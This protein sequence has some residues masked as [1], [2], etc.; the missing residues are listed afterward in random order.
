M[1]CPTASTSEGSAIT[2][3]SRCVSTRRMSASASR[4]SR[5]SF[6]SVTFSR[7]GATNV[8]T[9]LP[10]P[11]RSTVPRPS[12]WSSLRSMDSSEVSMSWY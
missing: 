11:M 12:V 7:P 3:V 9:A 6:E 5:I 8:W 1:R 10:V 2:P 4:A